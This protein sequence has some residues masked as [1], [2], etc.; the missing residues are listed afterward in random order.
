MTTTGFKIGT[1]DTTDSSAWQS[2]TAT[3]TSNDPVCTLTETETVAY[4]VGAELTFAS[5]QPGCPYN[6][7]FQSSCGTHNS[8]SAPQAIYCTS[9]NALY[10]LQSLQRPNIFLNVFCILLKMPLLAKMSK[11]CFNFSFLVRINI[12]HGLPK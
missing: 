1:L 4:S 8:A 2:V 5:L 11:T 3:A 10:L 12:L 7:S 9:K 6:I